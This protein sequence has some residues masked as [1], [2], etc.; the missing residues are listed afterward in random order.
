MGNN[1][2]AGTTEQQQKVES[3]LSDTTNQ[4]KQQRPET[5]NKWMRNS[6]AMVPSSSTS[7]LIKYKS[8]RPRLPKTAKFQVLKPTH[9]A[10]NIISVFVCIH[11]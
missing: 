1:R 6:P 4:L 9:A 2:A 11:N 7:S 5:L 8:D 3:V 10:G